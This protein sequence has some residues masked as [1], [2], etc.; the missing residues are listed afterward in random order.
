MEY[1][2]ITAGVEPGGIINAQQVRLLVGYMLREV[3]EPMGRQ[4]LPELLQ[5]H[6]LANFFEVNRAI[7]E[8]LAKGS[9]QEA[10]GDKLIL[11]EQGRTAVNEWEFLLPYSAKQKA[12]KAVMT[13]L[14]R[15]RNQR[16]NRVEIRP[17]ERGLDVVCTVLDGEQALLEL[18]LWVPNK[19]QA[20]IVKERFLNDP[21]S[22]Y[23]S[24]VEMLMEEEQPRKAPADRKPENG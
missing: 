21:L 17:R 22:C 16:E 24:T 15:L 11:T 8:L 10:E 2:A 5:Y 19:A 4:L 1:D 3:P 13:A 18:R 20:E 6:G 14:T 7:E 9:L 12:V 23:R